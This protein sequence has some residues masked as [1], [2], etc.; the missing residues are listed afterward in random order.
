[1]SNKQQL[2]NLPDD[3]AKVIAAVFFIG[4]R[5][6][7]NAYQAGEATRQPITDSVMVGL[8]QIYPNDPED[9][10]ERAIY[11]GSYIYMSAIEP[12]LQPAPA[13]DEIH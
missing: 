5:L 7:N 9:V 8:K 6:G 3:T 12:L 1:M 2:P 4:V 10:L 13:Q 11:L